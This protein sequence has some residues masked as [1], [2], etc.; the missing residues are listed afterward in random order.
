MGQFFSRK[1]DRSGNN[2]LYYSPYEQTTTEPFKLSRNKSNNEPTN[3]KPN[4]NKQT[5]PTNNKPT[6]NEPNWE[7]LTTRE[8]RSIKPPP[9]NITKSIKR[10]YADSIIRTLDKIVGSKNNK[11]INMN[12]T[13]YL[14]Q[15]AMINLIRL[16]D[17]YQSND[18]LRVILK[19]YNGKLSGTNINMST[20]KKLHNDVKPFSVLKQSGGYTRRR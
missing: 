5:K 20:L 2:Q 9:I 1:H 12:A 15:E 14:K 16:L 18:D 4:N 8:S 17:E 6:N 13:E 3:N 10:K 11:N 19:K 7:A